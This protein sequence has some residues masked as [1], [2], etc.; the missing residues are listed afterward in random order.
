MLLTWWLR[1]PTAF[2]SLSGIDVFERFSF[3]AC[4]TRLYF[5]LVSQDRTTWFQV[6]TWWRPG[7][8]YY[9]I[10]TFRAHC[11]G[12]TSR[13]IARSEQNWFVVPCPLHGLSLPWLKPIGVDDV[14]DG[15][16]GYNN[17]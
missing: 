1:T 14:K 16:E 10:R 4:R 9:D 13:E 8:G 2:T 17:Q 15:N 3:R 11:D 6:G 5:S 7:L 12:A